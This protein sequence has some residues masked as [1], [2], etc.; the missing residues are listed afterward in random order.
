MSPWRAEAG[1]IRV[2][3]RLTPKASTDR[4][5]GPTR[6]SDDSIVI[7]ARVRAVPEDGRANKALEKL[8]AAT[9]GVPRSSVRV[10]AGQQS[11]LKQV[12]IE[13]DAEALMDSAGRLWPDP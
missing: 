4:I 5:D 2:A 8:L 1:G 11:R 13:G 3:V 7:A 6:L 12:H 10:V 9:F